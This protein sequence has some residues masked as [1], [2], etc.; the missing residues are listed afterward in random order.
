MN[1]IIA[2]RHLTILLLRKRK[3]PLVSEEDYDIMYHCIVCVEIYYTYIMSIY[4]LWVAH[5]V[6]FMLKHVTLTLCQFIRYSWHT[7]HCSRSRHVTLTLCQFIRYD[8]VVM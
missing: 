1:I 7:R 6:L 2:N 3:K 5:N 8:V 4:S